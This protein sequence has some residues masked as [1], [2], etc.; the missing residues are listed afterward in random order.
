M[1]FKLKNWLDV[2]PHRVSL[3]NQDILLG[4]AH[5]HPLL[6]ELLDGSERVESAD[7]QAK[8]LLNSE[9]GALECYWRH[10]GQSHLQLQIEVERFAARQKSFPAKRGSVLNQALG[11]KTKS[12]LD[13]TGGWG[14][15]ALLLCSQGYRVSLLERHPLMVL[16]L[17]DAMQRLACTDW[18]SRQA[19]EVPVVVHANAQD[20]LSTQP[21]DSLAQWDCFYLD[22]MFPPKRKRSAAANKEMQFLHWLLDQ[23]NDAKELAEAAY[24]SMTKRLVI[25]RPAHAEPLLSGPTERF[26]GKLVHYDVYLK[27]G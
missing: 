27:H 5:L 14:A 10:E 18:V 11:S 15:D 4:N 26:S 16:M 20:W 3:G 13:L 2:Q 1:K 6:R 7:H 21:A 17:Q 12:V 22:P 24:S 25:K 19:V 8:I 9:D 23:E